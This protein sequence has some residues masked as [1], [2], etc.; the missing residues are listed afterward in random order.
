MK[1]ILKEGKISLLLPEGEG[2]ALSGEVHLIQYDNKKYIVRRCEEIS[3]AKFY[4]SISKKF[5]KYGFLPKFLGR[6]G[7][8]VLYE[9][10][11][12][13]DL[14]KEESLST[15]EQ[16]GRI[17]G[18]INRVKIQGKV[19]SRFNKQL[20][21]LSTGNYVLNIKERTR[22]NKNKNKGKRAVLKKDQIEKIKKIYNLLKKK[23][24]PTLAL[25][26]ND[27]S[28]NNFRIDKKGKVYLVDIEG[29]KPRIKGFGFAKFYLKFGKT[30]RRINAYKKGYNSVISGE[31]LT[32][33][34]LD[35]IN[36]NFFVQK[37]LY[38]IK[39]FDKDYKNT[40]DSLNKIL[41]KY[42]DK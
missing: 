20:R 31:Y 4:E 29:I 40:L 8:D 25:D 10:I 2:G 38:N 16:M 13:R 26:V 5:E 7:K 19:E 23:V 9:Y 37:I 34:Y 12:G 42:L 22:A 11:E 3:Q 30:T 1:H 36:I 6:F 15:I 14:T 35:F 18:Y 21:E 41:I 39:I 28:P 32:E 27:V 24:N 33:E 17:A